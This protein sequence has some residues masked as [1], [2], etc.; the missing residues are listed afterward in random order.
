MESTHALIQETQQGFESLAELVQETADN[1]SVGNGVMRDMIPVIEKL[2]QM[3]QLVGQLKGH[4]TED[5]VISDFVA[6]STDTNRVLVYI[7]EAIGSEDLVLL[8]DLLQYELKGRI[9]RWLHITKEIGTQ[10]N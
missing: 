3:F 2:D 10:I 1:L 9:D 7:M 5:E 8:S 4:L 6:L